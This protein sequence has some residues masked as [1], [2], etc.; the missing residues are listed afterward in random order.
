MTNWWDTIKPFL[1]SC[2]T[3]V[4][5]DESS[6]DRLKHKLPILTLDIHA[7]SD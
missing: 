5:W 4:W 3:I 7:E 2:G 1:A 6:L